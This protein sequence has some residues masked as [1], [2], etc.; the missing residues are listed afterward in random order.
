MSA[1]ASLTYEERVAAASAARVALDAAREAELEKAEL[2]RVAAHN[3]HQIAIR[4]LEAKQRDEEDALSQKVAVYANEQL[5]KALGAFFASGTR[6]DALA[7]GATVRTV[8][9]ETKRILG[10]Q[11]APLG[12]NRAILGSRLWIVAASTIIRKDASALGAFGLENA[13]LDAPSVEALDK[14]TGVCLDPTATAGEIEAAL[15]RLE[16]AVARA[17]RNGNKGTSPESAAIWGALKGHASRAPLERAFAAIDAA[18]K[19]REREAFE[20]QQSNIQRARMGEDD[21]S[22]PKDWAET[23]RKSSGRVIQRPDGRLVPEWK[24][25]Y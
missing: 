20:L 3:A 9:A 22:W 5:A 18:R 12:P 14:A 7:C 15:H 2:I 6:Q 4:D 8:A 24:G 13:G 21:P 25:S 10:E 11:W 23:V 17:A 16:D 1:Q 19:A